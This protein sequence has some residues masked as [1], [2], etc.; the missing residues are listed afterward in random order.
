MTLAFKALRRMPAALAVLGLLLAMQVSNAG[1]VN[2]AV[3]RGAGAGG[4]H[5]GA[6]CPGSEAGQSIYDQLRAR[7]GG[8]LATALTTQQHLAY[9]LDQTAASEQALTDQ[10][11]QEET[12][13]ATLQDQVSTLDTQI[14][15]TQGR[16]DTEQTQLVALVRALYRQPDS[17]WLLIA[18]AGS[19][20]DALLASSELVV[21]GQRAHAIEGQ[22]QAALTKQQADRDARQ[23]ALDRESTVKDSLVSSLGSLSDLMSQQDDLTNQLADLI[24]RIQAAEAAVGSQPA[25]V[26][27]NLAHLLEQEEAD[28]VAKANQE[29]W[30][31]AA[32]GSG[33]AALTHE[34]PKD[35]TLVGLAISWPIFGAK[36]TQPFGPTSFALEPPRGGYAHFH[37]GVDLAAVMGTP[38]VATASGIVVAVGHSSIGYGNYVV[39]AHGGGV[40]SLY[41]HL[42]E[43]DVSVGAKVMR[44]QRVGR[45]GSTGWSTGPHLHFELRVEGQPVDPMLYLPEL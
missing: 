44:G 33:L 4:G 15:D 30:N 36:V 9:L 22:L 14:S 5:A 6:W 3:C 10:I 23:A 1:A 38:V 35:Q 18:Q 25:D 16:I 19:L 24:T 43:T 8:D 34:L 39:V 40:M 32:V 26:L 17:F 13:I 45:E 29:A 7:L 42:L 28:I 11:S 12:Q 21:A 31:Q 41:G 2:P 20:H 27:A 37:T